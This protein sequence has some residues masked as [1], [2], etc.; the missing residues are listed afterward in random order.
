MNDTV[1]PYQKL[2]NRDWT[3]KDDSRHNLFFESFGVKIKIT[4]DDPTAIGKVGSILVKYLPG[5]FSEIEPT[6]TRHNFRMKLEPGG[7]NVFY[8]GRKKIYAGEDREKSLEFFCSEVRRTIAEFAVGRVFIHA[9]AVGWKGKAILM[10]ANSFRGKTS[11]TAA[12]VKRGALYYSDEFGVLDEAGFL[13]PFPTA[14]A[15]RGIAGDFEQVETP[16]EKL[17][18]Q[19]AIEKAPV[20]MILITGYKK[21]GKWNPQTLSSANGMMELIKHTLPIRTDPGFVLG[22]LEKTTQKAL[23]VKSN[24]PDVAEAAGLILDFFESHC[25]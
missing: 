8:K 17:G 12:L 23:V 5:A 20:G 24:R 3:S 11:L 4:A 15:V 21:T 14:L 7:K 9:G 6:A 25:L 13:H 19:A 1:P 10:P 16:V 2:R 18:G 22:V